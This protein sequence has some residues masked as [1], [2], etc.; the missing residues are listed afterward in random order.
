MAGRKTSKIALPTSKNSNEFKPPPLAAS[1]SPAVLHPQPRALPAMVGWPDI[2]ITQL[3]LLKLSRPHQAWSATSNVSMMPQSWAFSEVFLVLTGR[4]SSTSTLSQGLE[5]SSAW[6]SE[7]PGCFGPQLSEPSSHPRPSTI[8]SPEM[9]SATSLLFWNG[10]SILHTLVARKMG[11]Q[12]RKD[13]VW[14]CLGDT[15]FEPASM[16]SPCATAEHL[17]LPRFMGP[18]TPYSKLGPTI[19]VGFNPKSAKSTVP[20]MTL[21]VAF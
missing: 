6:L 4:R 7:D 2:F 12:V 14:M 10:F 16:R 5:A 15:L 17:L 13:G 18:L 8:G 3:S 11:V 19:F 9:Q 1:R 20:K 21:P